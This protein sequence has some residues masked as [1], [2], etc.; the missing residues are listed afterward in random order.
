MQHI[1]RDLE[2]HL[3]TV[4]GL[5]SH[6]SLCSLSYIIIT[7]QQKITNKIAVRVSELWTSSSEEPSCYRT[8]PAKHRQMRPDGKGAWCLQHGRKIH[9]SCQP[10]CSAV[11]NNQS[12]CN[13]NNS[14]SAS[15]ADREEAS[16]GDGLLFC[17]RASLNKMINGTWGNHKGDLGWLN[18]VF[19][20][21]LWC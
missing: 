3:S 2:S 21:V 15:A 1:K 20:F 4:A 17:A 6:I 19:I 18:R 14:E 11:R 16:W 8:C 13:V 7:L 5:Y 12:P 9:Y 10:W